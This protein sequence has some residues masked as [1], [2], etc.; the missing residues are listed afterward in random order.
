MSS[1]GEP[2]LAFQSAHQPWP[3]NLVINPENLG[4]VLSPTWLVTTSD[5][6]AP[7]G[8]L[9]LGNLPHQ[10]RGR[11]PHSESQDP[12]LGG[13]ASPTLHNCCFPHP[14]RA[15]PADCFPTHTTSRVFLF[16]LAN[17]SSEFP[18]CCLCTHINHSLPNP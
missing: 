1:T 7:S 15:S 14:L 2:T 12:C 8:F 11:R 16:L 17:Y 6:T 10:S 13:P 5:E 9:V 3:S 18:V 4:Q